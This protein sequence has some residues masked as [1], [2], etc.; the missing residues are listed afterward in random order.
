M[1]ALPDRPPR[2]CR[3]AVFRLFGLDVL[4]D[5]D[6]RP[7]LIEGQRK[8]GVSALSARRPTEGKENFPPR[9]ALKSHETGRP[10]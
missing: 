6:A 1:G 2:R 7:W 8:P 10:C 5:A 4:I 9:N 3:R